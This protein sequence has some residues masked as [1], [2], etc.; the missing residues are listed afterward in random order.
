MTRDQSTEVTVP[1]TSPNV[2]V[3]LL[4]SVAKCPV[5]NGDLTKAGAVCLRR[6]TITQER[7]LTPAPAKWTQSGPGPRTN[8]RPG[9]GAAPG[10]RLLRDSHYCGARLHGREAGR[11]G[12]AQLAPSVTADPDPGH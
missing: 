2:T 4:A 6:R 11:P 5:C 9:A 1:V 7:Y 10:P 3:R 8:S 12:A